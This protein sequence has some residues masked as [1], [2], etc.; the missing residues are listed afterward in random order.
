MPERRRGLGRGLGALIPPDSS[1][2]TQE[3]GRPTD[4]FFAERSSAR[5]PDDEP[6]DPPRSRRRAAP[7]ARTRGGEPLRAVPDPDDGAL[8]EGEAPV[9][10]ARVPVDQVVPNPR[11]PRREFEAGAMAELVH[12]VRE[13]GV[14]Q[15]IVV[16][17]APNPR[18]GARYELVMGER[19]WRASVAAGLATVPAVVRRTADDDLLRDALL[20]NLHRS[21][22]NPLEEAGAYQQLLEDFGCT[23]DQLADRLGRSRPQVTN[24]LRLLRLPVAVQRRVASGALTAGHARALLGL[25][26]PALE[27]MA[28]RVLVE[29]LSVRAT[30]QAVAASTAA[31]PSRPP[32]PASQLALPG[33]DGMV[34]ALSDRL[35]APVR[36]AMGARKGRLVVEFAGAEDLERILAVLGSGAADAGADDAGQVVGTGAGRGRR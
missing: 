23:H 14:L 12:S 24:T 13:I 7:A 17:P 22:L 19:R 4:V 11:Q 30:E 26:G 2:A 35:A 29:N 20:E 3:G 8:P 6:A 16:R 36:V 27:A 34:D 10:L 9:V 28:D 1:S 15:P 32:Q 31:T 33:L 25:S 5:I 21:A 18:E